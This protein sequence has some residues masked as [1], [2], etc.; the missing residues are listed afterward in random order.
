MKKLSLAFVGKTTN[1]LTVRQPPTKGGKMTVAE[2]VRSNSNNEQNNVYDIYD[3]SLEAVRLTIDNYN[4]YANRT[5]IAWSVTDNFTD[6][7]YRIIELSV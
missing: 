2:F 4:D 3:S 7:G 5:I 1:I 6:K